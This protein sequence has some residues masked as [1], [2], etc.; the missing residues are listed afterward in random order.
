MDTIETVSDEEAAAILGVPPNTLKKWRCTR[1]QNIPFIKVGRRVRY[2]RRDLVAYLES[3]TVRH[4][5]DN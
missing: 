1:E 4:E 2:W 3:K 5:G